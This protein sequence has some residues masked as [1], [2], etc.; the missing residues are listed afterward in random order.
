MLAWISERVARESLGTQAQP[1][2]QSKPHRRRSYSGAAGSRL[3]ADFVASTTSADGEIRYNLRRLRDRSRELAR[4]DSY[5][6]R[7]L[8]LMTQNVIGEH[9]FQLQSRA[10]NERLPGQEKGQLDAPGNAIVENAWK[11]WGKRCTVDRRHSWLDVQRLV[12]EGLAR[13]GEILIRF[14][15]GRK[16]PNGL[17]LQLLE[18]DYLDETYTTT[19]PSGGRINMGVE[20][21][22]YDAPVAYYLLL[23]KNSGV[24]PFDDSA[25]SLRSTNRVRV[26]AEEIIHLYMP[27]RSQQ[28]R[29]VPWIS[30]S[31]AR[32]KML[33]GLEEATI[34]AARA[35]ASKMGFITSPDG[36]S[37]VGEDEDPYSPVMSAEPGSIQQLPAGTS[38]TPWNPDYPASS[39]SDFHKSILRGIASG[40]G[41]SY[42]SLA[43][44]LEGVSY[45]SIRQG[46]LEE[47]DFYRTIQS[48]LIQ[49][50]C[51]PVCEEWLSMF[52]SQSD[53]PLPISKFDK[54]S[55][56]VEFRGRGFSWIDPSKEIKAEHEAV[57]SGFKSLND[58]ARSYGKDVE[59]VFAQM[60]A[61]KQMAERYGIQLAYEPLGTGVK[62]QQLELLAAMGEPPEQEPPA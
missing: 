15:R 29:G 26:P 33:D 24:H 56:A 54:F 1:E 13:D 25:T 45:S 60:Q 40:L 12:M 2:Q 22:Q 16:Y 51:E 62:N 9:G 6:Q 21:D 52:M 42:V 5:M 30:A 36:D 23:G 37:Y 11:R 46:A 8:Q 57:Q 53:T 7:Y 35:G 43:N 38:F 3:L 34:V 18:P 28:T 48:F 20:L 44:N 10:R 58:V 47:R 50:L 49:H 17:A 14:V 59:E 41:V 27:E 4:N 55:S 32:M 39:F 19:A 31:M 61:D